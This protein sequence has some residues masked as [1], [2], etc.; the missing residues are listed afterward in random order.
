MKKKKKKREFGKV[1]TDSRF[2]PPLIRY[3]FLNH[4]I[5]Y[6]NHLKIST[7]THIHTLM[8]VI[9]Y[10][11]HTRYWLLVMEEAYLMRV[12]KWVENN[13][14]WKIFFKNWLILG[15]AYNGNMSLILNFF[16]I[17]KIVFQSSKNSSSVVNISKKIFSKVTQYEKCK[18]FP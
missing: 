2:T 10:T 4:E 1:I 5:F 11:L 14:K 16:V 15:V 7:I 18:F 8:P 13:G 17:F 3:S 9:I 6:P 12:P